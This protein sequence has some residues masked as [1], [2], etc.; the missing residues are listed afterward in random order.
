VKKYSGKNISVEWK[1]DLK[2]TLRDNFSNKKWA[3]LSRYVID[4]MILT[5]IDKGLSPVQGERTFQKYKNPKKY[6][7]HLKQNNKPNLKLTGQMLSHYDVKDSKNPMEISFGIHN[8]A[9][10]K[11][12]IKAKANNEGTQGT[13]VDELSKSKNR[14]LNAQ[15]KAATKGIPSRPFVP[16]KGQSFTRDI[17]LEVRKHF[18]TILDIAIKK[19]MKK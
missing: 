2:Q 17:I 6:P 11:E 1:F 8:T 5:K 18:A 12:Q 16:R 14:K 4:Q 7:G 15:V 10:E 3:D 19:G 13:L 9:P